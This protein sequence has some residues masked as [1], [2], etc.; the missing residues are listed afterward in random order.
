MSVRIALPSCGGER[1]M[2]LLTQAGL[3]HAADIG[4]C[5]GYRECARR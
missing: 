4:S 1:M 3:T 2:R 5:G